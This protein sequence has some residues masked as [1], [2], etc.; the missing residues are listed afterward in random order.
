MFHFRSLI[1]FS[2]QWCALNLDQYN[3]NFLSIPDNNEYGY[4]LEV[5]L[6][7]PKELFELHKDLPLPSS[8][9]TSNFNIKYSQSSC[10]KEYI[11]A[12]KEVKCQKRVKM[13]FKN[14]FYKLMNLAP[15]GKTIENVKKYRDVKLI[16]KWEGR[17]GAKFYIS[18]PNF[19]NCE[20]FDKDFVLIEMRRLK[21]KYNKPIYRVPKIRTHS[22]G[23]LRT[24]C[25]SRYRKTE[26][27]SP[28]QLFLLYLMLLKIPLRRRDKL[29]GTLE[30]QNLQ[31]ILYFKKMSFIPTNSDLATDLDQEMQKDAEHSVNGIP[32]NARTLKTF[33]RE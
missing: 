17:Y 27:I 5:D 1:E 25:F 14:F 29:N 32:E 10:L 12:K 19:H 4:V 21:I 23:I 13:I 22:M 7:Y 18:Q 24:S 8:Y 33:P 11:D 15:F 28:Q 2:Y 3:E 30:Y 6:H 16:T 20:I 31:L 26:S 9:N